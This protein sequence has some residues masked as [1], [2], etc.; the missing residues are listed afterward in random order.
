MTDNQLRCP[1]CDQY[2][3]YT[4]QFRINPE[5]KKRIS[6]S[7]GVVARGQYSLLTI[8]GAIG[9][10]MFFC[11]GLF[12]TQL[13]SA[14]MFLIWLFAFM[15]ATAAGFFLNQQYLGFSKEFDHY[16]QVCGYKWTTSDKALGDEFVKSKSTKVKT[17]KLANNKKV[18]KSKS[19]TK[20]KKVIPEN[21]KTSKATKVKE[22]AKKK[23]V[24]S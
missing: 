16:C 9:S 21:P 7:G 18:L 17:A 20:T 12:E 22:V 10:L 11:I 8:L 5:T 3:I 24:A 1:N 19:T 13:W 23:K 6:V 2:K 14:P 15:A 4:L